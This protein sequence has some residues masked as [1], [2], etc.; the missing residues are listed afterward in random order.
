ML[1]RILIP[2]LKNRKKQF[3]RLYEKLS[4]QIN[5]TSLGGVKRILR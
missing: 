1:F 3:H 5:G 2:T 4:N